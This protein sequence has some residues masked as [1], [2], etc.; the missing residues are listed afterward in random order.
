MSTLEE[1]MA[2]AAELYPVRET[3]DGRQRL[4]AVGHQ[5]AYV[6]SKTISGEQVEQ[7]AK[8]IWFYF[9]GSNLEGFDRPAYAYDREKCMEAAT[10]AFRAA[11]FYVE[12]AA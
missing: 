4:S 1:L 8:A 3:E 6:R 10:T 2:E 5:D 11:G 7:A 12:E 9:V